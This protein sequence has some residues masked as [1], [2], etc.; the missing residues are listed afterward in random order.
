M[1]P[2]SLQHSSRK[3]AAR[4]QNRRNS[5][6]LN[7]E[8]LET[9]DVPYSIG[10]PWDTHLISYSY[11]N[12]LDGVLRDPSGA[13]LSA[14]DLRTATREAMGIWASVAN[15]SF[16]ELPDSGPAASETQYDG[17]G[18][19]AIR[20]GHHFIDGPPPASGL[21]VLAHCLLPDDDSVENGL[22]GDVHFDE[23]P[24][25]LTALLETATHELG[26]GLGMNHA[27]GDVVNNTA[28][29]PKPA[30]MDAVA[31]SF[32]YNGLGSGY[33]LPDDV[34]G[35]QALYGSG[36]GFVLD[37]NSIMHVYGTRGNDALLVTTIGA[38]VFVVNA[39][40]GGSFNRSLTGIRGIALHGLDGDDSFHIIRSNGVRVTAE[41]NAGND[42]LYVLG[43][44]GSEV[45]FDGGG[46]FAGG[47]SPGDVV[48]IDME[49]RNMNMDGTTASAGST[50]IFYNLNGATEEVE[51][52]G[53]NSNRLTITGTSAGLTDVRSVQTVNVQQ[54]QLTNRVNIVVPTNVTLG[55]GGNMSGIRGPVN[56][57]SGASVNFTIDDSASTSPRSLMLTRTSL[58]G[59]PASLTWGNS[60][61]F[62]SFQ[63]Q[64]G[65]GDA[66]GGNQIHVFDSPTSK[67]KL[68][69]GVGYD[70]I[71]ITATTGPVEIDG[72][73][74]FDSINI[75]F[76]GNAQGLRG[77]VTI[78]NARGTSSVT[79][80][81]S[82][83]P[84]PRTGILYKDTI[85]G[86][87]ILSGV[88][89]DISMRGRDISS[90]TVHSGNAGNQFRIHDTPKSGKLGNTTTTINTGRGNDSVLVTGTTGKLNL[91][92]QDGADSVRFSRDGLTQA[93][94]GTVTLT[95]AAGRTDVDV[96]DSADASSRTVI[97]YH[98]AGTGLNILSGLSSA[99]ILF[100]G[101]DL[102]SFVVRTGHAGNQ[103]RIHDTPT[104]SRQA[105]L[106][107]VFRTGGGSDTVQVNGTTGALSL[108]L[109]LGTNHVTVG[110]TTAGLDRIQ[111][112]VTI[113]GAGGTNNLNVDDRRSSSNSDLDHTITPTTYFR[114]GAA[115]VSYQNLNRFNLL[116]GVANDTVH[117][118][119][120]A[121]STLSNTFRV[122]GGAGVN[123][124]DY[125][126]PGSDVGAG[127][128]ARSIWYQAEGDFT[129]SAG[130]IDGTPQNG[131]SFAPG[132]SGQAFDFDGVDD[133]ISLGNDPSLELP[134]SM[135]VGMWLN[136]RPYSNGAGYK[137][138]YADF[139]VGGGV[140]QG[141]LGIEGGRLFFFQ[142]FTDGSSL[143][144]MGTTD[145]VAGQWY[146]VAVVRD[147]TAKTVRLYVN[148]V[149]EANN[150]YTGTPVGLQQEKLI[151]TSLPIGFPSDFFDGRLDDVSIFDHALSPA[152]I[153]SLANAGG[154]AAD[155]TVNLRLGTATGLADG[156][157]RIQNV[158]G[159]AGND[160]LVG[161]GGN[162]LDGGDGRDLLISGARASTLIGGNGDD[163]LIAGTTIHD[164]NPTSLNAIRSVWN[165]SDDYSTRVMTLRAGLLSD[166]AI[167]RNRQPDWMLGQ[168]GLDMFFAY[169]DDT[170]DWTAGESLFL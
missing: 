97:F 21:S 127:G 85:T 50:R 67:V 47:S 25:T 120:L 10:V 107:T 86:N 87:Y 128:P 63:F 3:S 138:F 29:P 151:G 98:D 116:G 30:V 91:N 102:N 135:S 93:I 125:S 154:Q 46:N 158:I 122:D 132:V 55:S 1:R 119:E 37:A 75:G 144:T 54:T 76:A 88:T 72:Q 6:R 139:D 150:A 137:Y 82:A 36:L 117:V 163:I 96:D 108:E 92:G 16:Y 160:I 81:N 130:T 4:S 8:N 126:G 18:R 140:S 7:L 94:Q 165:S 5:T 134:G 100:R 103:F 23:E 118:A 52:A 170:G 124:L 129:D 60:V 56:I 42:T 12:L 35:I 34:G 41:G 109:G 79:L 19:P 2:F 70:E 13:Q 104:S 24:F 169:V 15:V 155:V 162:V 149:E 168:D 156:I 9:R 20:W 32:S 73:A 48:R 26:H 44:V 58:T 141:S 84:T 121:N 66:T 11:S 133:Y 69:T 27:N 71:R 106:T 152:E 161:N 53:N 113:S 78:S 80:D 115:S 51:F 14:G 95:N 33:L 101:E 65:R 111:A 112:N 28:P 39:T 74:S 147:D 49:G 99:D 166:S 17:T 110:S 64:G 164:T 157:V 145:L 40:T 148:G 142:S 68:N 61:R 62:A 90:L 153:A 131:V 59:F 31:G 123:T 43:S 77:L 83:D 146:H 57:E 143:Q 22:A 114:T 105:G 45:T 89:G 167:S 159:G 136:Y 38:N